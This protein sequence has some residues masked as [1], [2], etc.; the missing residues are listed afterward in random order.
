MT[1]LSEAGPRDFDCGCPIPADG[2][3]HRPSGLC[4]ACGHKAFVAVPADTW[5]SMSFCEG[6]WALVCALRAEQEA[7]ALRKAQAAEQRC[8]KREQA[9]QVAQLPLLLTA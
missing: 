3:L 5:H 1:T 4:A 9:R 8:R 6:C 2:C 7:K